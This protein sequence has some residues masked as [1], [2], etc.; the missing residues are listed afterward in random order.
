MRERKDVKENDSQNCGL[1]NADRGLKRKIFELETRNSQPGTVLMAL[2][3][4]KGL[5]DLS[6]VCLLARTG[7]MQVQRALKLRA[8]KADAECLAGFL[9]KEPFLNFPQT[10]RRG[11][12]ASRPLALRRDLDP[13]ELQLLMPPSSDLDHEVQGDFP[14][15]VEEDLIRLTGFHPGNGVSS[16]RRMDIGL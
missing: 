16:D 5:V 15:A 7:E 13:L 6:Q 9:V 3:R 12:S 10:V 4:G 8:I 14:L 2:Q 1:R 11:M